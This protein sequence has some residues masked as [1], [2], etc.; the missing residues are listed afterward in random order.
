MIRL[1]FSL[2][3]TI[4]RYKLSCSQVL[5]M[6]LHLAT[7]HMLVA[8]RC[9]Y[10]CHKNKVCLCP[11]RPLILVVLFLPIA[12]TAL[13]TWLL[14]VGGVAYLL[15]FH[16]C[17]SFTFTFTS[18]CGLWKLFS[19]NLKLGG[20]PLLLS[21]S[22]PFKPFELHSRWSC[23]LSLFRP[24]TPSHFLLLNRIHSFT[25]VAAAFAFAVAVAVA[26]P[27]P[28]FVHMFR[29]FTMPHNPTCVTNARPD[30]L[31]TPCDVCFLL[32]VRA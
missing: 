15:G 27:S 13:L 23:P 2:C 3:A 7:C 11:G 30:L 17:A 10:K 29:R 20:M 4:Y 32:Y 21:F 25:N 12:H 14:R 28:A 26:S 1:L 5:C 6:P 8:Q 19:H 31:T 22:L 16:H 9:W 24:V 18:T